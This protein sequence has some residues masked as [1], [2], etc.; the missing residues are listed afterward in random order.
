MQNSTQTLIKLKTH[1]DVYKTYPHLL[2]T[3]RSLTLPD[4]P[5]DM[6]SISLI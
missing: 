1:P 5:I 3:H 6:H 2:F 4:S